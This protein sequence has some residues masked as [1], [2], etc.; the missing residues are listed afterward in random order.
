[1][2]EARTVVP[3]VKGLNCPGC[4]NALELRSMGR[5][6]SVTCP[7]C[8]RVLD[9]RDPNLKI[10]EE[11]FGGQRLIPEIPLGKRG[12]LSGAEYEV[13]GFQERQVIVDTVTYSWY[14]YLLF[15]PFKGYKYLVN[16]MGHWNE[17]T[18]IHALPR[19]SS[20]ALGIK[21]VDYNG[22]NF[23]H[24]QSSDAQTSYVFGEFPWEIHKGETVRSDDFIAPPRMLSRE[25]YTGE[26][27]WS[28]A[29]YRD[30][31]QIA[32][33]FG[34]LLN[35]PSSGTPYANQPNPY[36]GKPT[37]AWMWYVASVAAMFLVAVFLSFASSSKVVFNRT[38]TVDAKSE[39]DKAF[40][41]DPF[42][43]PSAGMLQVDLRAGVSN[44]EAFVGVT[45][46]NEK[47]GR[48]WEFARTLSHYSGTD[49]GESWTEGSKSATVN[50]AGIPAGTYYFRIAHNQDAQAGTLPRPIRYSIKARRGSGIAWGLFFL[51]LLLLAIPPI[52]LTLQKSSFETRRWLESDYAPEQSS[53]N[54]DE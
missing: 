45:L 5:A 12:V 14:E 35:P 27:T 13:I 4:G 24:F 23:T 44:N 53:S 19:D 7:A 26:I 15:N 6:I 3:K 8:L 11:F 9:A 22:Q 31:R 54:N 28:L 50:L 2:N 29:E 18:P 32:Q 21:A 10:L 17:V 41:T 43:I 49:D 30:Y 46:I 20:N 36:I 1:M 38:F 51:V 16:S 42:E 39:E 40:V 37:H 33:A 47:S 34:V 25:K 48:G 52:W